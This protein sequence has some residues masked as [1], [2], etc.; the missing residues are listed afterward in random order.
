MVGLSHGFEFIVPK[1]SN[2]AVGDT[3]TVGEWKGNKSVR[4]CNFPGRI[5]FQN[6]TIVEP[7]EHFHHIL[8]GLFLSSPL[9]TT[10]RYRI[11]AV[12]GECCVGRTLYQK[13]RC[14][15]VRRIQHRKNRRPSHVGEE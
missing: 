1:S 11:E 3:F 4:K 14:V 12:T 7:N 13:F 6:I 5:P 9:K 10:A 2:L 15:R 8:A